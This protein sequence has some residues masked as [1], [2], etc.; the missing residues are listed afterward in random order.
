VPGRRRGARASDVSSA[1]V[2]AVEGLRSSAV[3][4]ALLELAEAEEGVYLVGG[5]VRDGMLGLTPRELDVVT[6]GDAPALAREL[7]RRLGVRAVVHG[8]F[9]TATVRADGCR[10][11]VAGTRTESYERPGALPTVCLGASLE[12]DLGR[13]DFTVNAIAVALGVP[14]RGQV[15]SVP[16]AQG[17]L[18]RGCLRV[19]HDQSF[20]EDPTR[21]LRLARYRARLRLVVERHTG[22]LAVAAR[23]GGALATVSGARLGGELRLA[24]EESD[25]LLAVEALD[26]LGLLG[27]LLEGLELDR[28]VAAAAALAL[29]E[30]GG[31]AGADDVGALLLAVCGWRVEQGRLHR[32]LADL[33]FPA[34]TRD[35][36]LTA[37]ADPMGLAAALGGARGPSE[38]VMVCARQP[39]AA[40]ALAGALGAAEPV[41]RWLG[42]LRHVHLHITGDDLVAAGVPPGPQIGQRLRGVLTRRLDGKLAE[43]REAELAAALEGLLEEEGHRWS[44]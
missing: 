8:R 33:D 6:Q 40:L 11:D 35:L 16:E 27:A 29:A 32:W 5:A 38:L 34:S 17:D 20:T 14:D 22:E 25:P 3:G 18:R 21:L 24:L 26:D 36:I 28:G 9:G 43:G 37:T 30:V 7:A 19:L 13:R 2:R 39:P 31:G 44:G 4:R 23:D 10:A 1:G 12:E 15:V 42:D 41:R